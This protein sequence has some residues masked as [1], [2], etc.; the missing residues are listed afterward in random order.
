MIK[1]RPHQGAGLRVPHLY[2]AAR[3]AMRASRRHR[4]DSH[5]RTSAALSASSSTASPASSEWDLIAGTENMTT[6]TGAKGENTDTM[7]RGTATFNCYERGCRWHR[8]NKGVGKIFHISSTKIPVCA[9]L[10]LSPKTWGHLSNKVQ[11]VH[12]CTENNLSI[13]SLP[14]LIV[15]L[16]K[17]FLHSPL[18]SLHTRYH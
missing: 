15:S 14:L 5:R 6:A 13:F 17:K 4:Q 9:L 7:R 12:Q 8:G 10:P 16:K 2:V 11:S 18:D 1:Q 3:G